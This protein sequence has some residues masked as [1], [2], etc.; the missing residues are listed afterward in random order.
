M[1]SLARVH[2][3]L[4]QD[5][6]LRWEPTIADDA[7]LIINQL[8]EEC[9]SHLSNVFTRIF[10]GRRLRYLLRLVGKGSGRS[11]IIKPHNFALVT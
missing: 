10:L 7:V 6:L 2:S 4:C 3:L 9:M 5:S 8:G 1:S 11:H